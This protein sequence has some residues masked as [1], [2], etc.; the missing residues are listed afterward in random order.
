VSKKISK[1]G[2]TK[3]RYGLARKRAE[4]LVTA[5]A[6]KG[7]P[8]DVREIAK[9]LGLTVLVEDLDEDISGLLTTAEKDRTI[10]VN[11]K[12]SRN[13]QRFSM[14]HEIGH[15]QLGHQFVHGEHVHVD[16]GVQISQRS[17]R[18]SEA[19]DA[20]EIEANQF[21]ACL[22]MPRIMLEAEVELPV[23]DE[24]VKVLARKFGVSEQAM[25]IRLSRLGFL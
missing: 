10:C 16:R 5:F 18:S 25:T 17:G 8:V 12:H 15:H 11:K 23:S 24:Q 1:G 6:F 20:K 9:K 4:G 3:V 7:P 14:A 21:A 2:K 13:R 19:I 22:L